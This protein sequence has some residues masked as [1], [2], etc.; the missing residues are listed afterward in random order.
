VAPTRVA[1]LYAS[2]PRVATTVI[3]NVVDETLGFVP[4]RS[5]P[6]HDVA[7]SK[8]MAERLAVPDELLTGLSSL[9]D[10]T[11][12]R[13]VVAQA[14]LQLSPHDRALLLASTG[15][16][17]EAGSTSRSVASL[18]SGEAARRRLADEYG[19]IARWLRSALEPE[20]AHVDEEEGVA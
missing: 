11:T 15:S 8:A 3:A 20:R 14:L 19:R 6:D 2:L 5:D 1:E 9:I 18:L 17:A 13:I 10:R 4:T 12:T 7:I 16:S